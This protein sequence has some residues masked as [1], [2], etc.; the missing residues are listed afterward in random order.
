[1]LALI[2]GNTQHNQ[3]RG[4]SLLP[5]TNAKQ[6]L[7]EVKRMTR[8][9]LSTQGAHVVEIEG[10]VPVM[11]AFL[12][13]GNGGETRI[14]L[15]RNRDRGYDDV[16]G[17][18]GVLAAFDVDDG[19]LTGHPED[20][21]DIAEQLVA[22]ISRHVEVCEGEEPEVSTVIQLDAAAPD[23]GR[24]LFF[25]PAAQYWKAPEGYWLQ[26]ASDEATEDYP[27]ADIDLDIVDVTPAPAVNVTEQSTHTQKDQDAMNTTQYTVNEMM[28]ALRQNAP[29]LID[30]GMIS[31]DIEINQFFA[32]NPRRI[33][34][35]LNIL[36]L[37]PDMV[38]QMRTNAPALAQQFNEISLLMAEQ[39]AEVQSDD[40]PVGVAAAIP[41]RQIPADM[42]LDLA[43]KPHTA[44]A[45]VQR[46]PEVGEYD[47]NVNTESSDLDDADMDEED[48][49]GEFDAAEADAAADEAASNLDPEV[50]HTNLN[51]LIVESDFDSVTEDNAE[52]VEVVLIN[53]INSAVAELNEA[54]EIDVSSLMSPDDIEDAQ[55][56]EGVE[57]LAGLINDTELLHYVSE[58]LLNSTED[59]LCI[60]YLGELAEDADVDAHGDDG[61]EE[62]D[63]NEVDDNEDYSEEEGDGEMDPT[64]MSPVPTSLVTIVPRLIVNVVLPSYGPLANLSATTLR[65]LNEIEGDDRRKYDLATGLSRSNNDKAPVGF[66]RKPF[67]T[68][69]RTLAKL[70][71]ATVIIPVSAE[72]LA[73]H[74]EIAVNYVAEHVANVDIAGSLNA[75]L[76]RLSTLPADEDGNLIVG[77]SGESEE[78]AI[79]ISSLM[80]LNKSIDLI[81]LDDS[82]N[83][84][85]TVVMSFVA[86]GFRNLKDSAAL[87][88]GLVKMCATA[89]ANTGISV[90]PSITFTGMDAY[91]S[92]EVRAAVAVNDIVTAMYGTVAE[93]GE[94]PV[95]IYNAARLSSLRTAVKDGDA[96]RVY[97][98]SED[99]EMCVTDVHTED[100]TPRADA[101]LLEASAVSMFDPD[102]AALYGLGG[103]TTITLFTFKE[104]EQDG[105]EDEME[106]DG[107]E[108][109][110]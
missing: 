26:G 106:M 63:N 86:P 6:A 60:A 13:Q 34:T 12:G 94:T 57:G 7:E 75:A 32:N 43:A 78:R 101:A 97:M 105:D 1:M 5:T 99:G 9:S 19:A 55:N 66:Y 67:N 77:F 4:K 58:D 11:V 21:I 68:L 62:E 88:R 70:A 73:E 30:L 76:E 91:L 110:E 92:E 47:D 14:N 35:V 82:Y 33:T 42:D 79:P 104:G 69:A 41:V 2:I 36:S 98:Q 46:R 38:E 27:V 39:Q 54:G 61:D 37:A 49:S 17:R 107:E 52:A 103:D 72:E 50:M 51:A 56:N 45:S 80:S 48:L 100:R 89:A 31:S 24:C 8:L 64:S 10:T 29:T 96:Y 3:V 65:A 95:A 15:E 74:Q 53:F 59:A 18:A 25:S 71:N 87:A 102:G 109:A 40:A 83:V 44:G 108:Q 22:V 85:L 28:V 20:V 84:E 81:E 93:F 16:L 90:S 23:I